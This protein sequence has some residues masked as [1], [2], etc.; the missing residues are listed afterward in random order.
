MARRRYTE[1]KK[2]ELVR[3]FE[4][5]GGSAAG[6]CR[7]HR[8]PYQSFLAWRR[9]SKA[10]PTGAAGAVEFQEVEVVSS[11]ARSTPAPAAVAPVVELVLGGGGMVLRVYEPRAVRP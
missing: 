9:A 11:E 10:P 8:L 7:K 3:K 1:E 6:F 4:R 2:A 5:D